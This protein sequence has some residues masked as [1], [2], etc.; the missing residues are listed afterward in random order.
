MIRLHIVGLV[1]DSPSV[2]RG[3]LRKAKIACTQFIIKELIPHRI[4]FHVC[5]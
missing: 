5:I 4:R 2:V 3:E 1:I